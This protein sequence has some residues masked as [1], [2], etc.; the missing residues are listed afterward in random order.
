[1]LFRK[2][3]KS[4]SILKQ[5]KLI[6]SMQFALCVFL[7]VAGQWVQVDLGTTT[8]VTGVVT[9]GR[10]QLPQWITSF[11]IEYSDNGILFETIQDENGNDIVSVTNSRNMLQKFTYC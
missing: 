8:T 11:K 10:F 9:Q 7:D 3:Y 5:H 6:I 2:R 1:M 4:K